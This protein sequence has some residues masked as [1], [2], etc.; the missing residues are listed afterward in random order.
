MSVIVRDIN[1][2]NSSKPVYWLYC[3]GAPESVLDRCTHLRDASNRVTTLTPSV[4]ATIQQHMDHYASEGLR[5][6][7]L[8]E[9]ANPNIHADYEDLSQYASY[10][11]RMTF[12]GLV[13]ML[14]PPRAGVDTAIAKCRTAGIRVI[15]ITGDNPTTA[16]SIC[17]RIGVF[18]H[19]VGEDET[20][21]FTEQITG[22]EK[23]SL[24]G[25]SFTGAQL[26][27]MT[28]QEKRQA[29]RT[30]LLFSR[31]E[32]KHK[33]EIVTLLKEQGEVVAMTGDGV[34]DAT[35]LRRSDIGIAMGS[36][37]DVA[38][39]ASKMVLQDDNFSTIVM[40]VEEGRAIYQ[41]TKQFIRYLISSNIGEVACIFLVAML[42][43]LIWLVT[44]V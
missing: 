23:P 27:Q 1:A 15:V 2:S 16:E 12:V 3:K 21:H 41:N 39:E 43:K 35:A 19:G 38:R 4:R 30:A 44:T 37:T 34:N 31:V 22:S 25:L 18:A 29:I 24:L 36:G 5:C 33:L 6:L 9:L 28:D 14:D 10:E 40:A 26:E 42:G 32:P 8:A 11:S 20:G 17:H 13:A 7:A